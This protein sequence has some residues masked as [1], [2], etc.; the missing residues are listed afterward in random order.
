M[1]LEIPRMLR[2]CL[3]SIRIP[4]FR[5]LPER[6]WS[7]PPAISTSNSTN[8]KELPSQ[9][10]FILVFICFHYFAAKISVRTLM[11]NT[12]VFCG[13]SRCSLQNIVSIYFLPLDTF[14]NVL[15]YVLNMSWLSETA[16][17]KLAGCSSHLWEQF[18]V[19]SLGIPCPIGPGI[20]FI[21][22]PC[23]QKPALENLVRQ[24]HAKATCQ[25]WIPPH[26]PYSTIM[27]QSKPTWKHVSIM[28][29]YETINYINIVFACFCLC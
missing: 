22:A 27:I 8:S 11:Q 26:Q 1:E 2:K 18:E 6:C 21:D 5:L 13:Q 24:K 14:D 4:T 3:E 20:V 19:T 23:D 17:W 15:W 25:Y 29:P 7:L 9:R 12:L 10:L 16:T 28:K